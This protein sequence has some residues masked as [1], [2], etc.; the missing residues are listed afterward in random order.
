MLT[1]PADSS[2][3]PLTELPVGQRARLHASQ[4]AGQERELLIALGLDDECRLR[5][6]KLGNPCIVQVCAT[7]IGLSEEVARHL[8]VVPEERS[9]LPEA[10]PEDRSASPGDR[11]Q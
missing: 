4:L 9:V 3:V 2:A 1:S 11:L 7:R 5:L 10:S 8:L 6:C